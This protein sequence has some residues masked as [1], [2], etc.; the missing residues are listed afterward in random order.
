MNR[1]LPSDCA[2]AA[3][4]ASSSNR[5]PNA[6]D[7]RLSLRLLA[8]TD[9]HGS[10]RGF[11][12][13]TDQPRYDGGLSRIASL[14][15]RARRG[16]PNSLLFD[17]GDLLQG[18]PL[19]DYWGQK[20]GI[21][22]GEIH[23]LIRAMNALGY[24]AAAPGNHDFDFGL[25]FL[26]RVM[27]DATFPYICANA[28]HEEK[29]G[30]HDPL[31]PPWTILTR[32]MTDETGCPR[33]IRIGLIGFVPAQTA[34]WQSIRL[35]SRLT[36]SD[37]VATAKAQI[38]ALRAAGADLVIA[39]AHTGIAPPGAPD[40]A[41]NVAVPLAAVE[42]IDVLICGH[43][44]LQ[45]PHPDG[46]LATGVDPANGCLHGKPA[47]LPGYWGSHLGVIDL[48]LCRDGEGPWRV[49]RSH[50]HLLSVGQP[51]ASTARAGR[52]TPEQDAIVRLTRQAH[53]EIRS[54][55]ACDL[56]RTAVPLNSFFSLVAPDAAM[57]L[58]AE[59]KADF[60]AH[61]VAHLPEADLPILAAVRPARFGGHRGPSGFVD[62]GSGPLHIR[63]V[64]DLYAYPNLIAAI[65]LSGQQIAQWLEWSASIYQRLRPGATDQPLLDPDFPFY[66]FDALY[67]LTYEIDLGKPARYAVNGALLDAGSRRIRDLRHQGRPVRATD[68]FLIATDSHRAA[69]CFF[70]QGVRILHFSTSARSVVIETIRRQGTIVPQIWP[71]WHFTPVP[72]AVAWFDTAPAA[73]TCLHDLHRLGLTAGETTPDG[74]LRMRM[75]FSRPGQTERQRP[76]VPRTF[77][78]HR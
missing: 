17:N 31:L 32:D 20:R 77:G 11:D 12:Y 48:S 42:G 4:V 60:L 66:N 71:V 56:G 35:G 63:D 39:L 50:S 41:E 55:L 8:T 67:G 70:G 16:A 69:S 5:L 49:E 78:P 18:S 75:D 57:S 2:H 47:V 29:G 64:L 15:T 21:H 13:T 65:R 27:R 45:F 40:A 74:F 44:H 51:S 6:C 62:I 23:P 22:P 26:I 76:G 7:I 58:V 36:T 72:G 59:A 34:I 68:M 28:F 43:S 19:A 53:A 73:R 10:L 52:P 24:D 25:D 3:S 38:P 9:L 61:A 33:Q 46:P 1:C 14:V 30:T 54:V 37:I